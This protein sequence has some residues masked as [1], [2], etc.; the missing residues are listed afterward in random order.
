MHHTQGPQ[1]HNRCPNPIFTHDLPGYKITL[2][3]TLTDKKTGELISLAAQQGKKSDSHIV[4]HTASKNMVKLG[5]LATTMGPRKVE[6]NRA[7]HFFIAPTMN[8]TFHHVACPQSPQE[9]QRQAN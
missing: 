6:Y 9:H 1:H 7:T 2:T 8:T 3:Y 4:C 5:L